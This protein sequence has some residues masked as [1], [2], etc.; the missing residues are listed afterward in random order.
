MTASTL[1]LLRESGLELDDLP[2]KLREMATQRR[3]EAPIRGRKDA[4]QMEQFANTLE[5]LNT[6]QREEGVALFD[7]VLADFNALMT[8]FEAAMEWLKGVE[9][10]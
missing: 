7:R 4:A 1:D 6:L 3:K 10:K 9:V 5:S 8:D 2:A